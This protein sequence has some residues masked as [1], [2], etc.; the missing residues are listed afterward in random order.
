[1]SLKATKD[2]YNK[3]KAIYKEIDDKYYDLQSGELDETEFQLNQLLNRLRDLKKYLKYIEVSDL[4]GN[5][6][7]K[8]IDAVKHNLETI[9]EAAY[10]WERF[11]LGAKY[12]I[13]LRDPIRIEYIPNLKLGSYEMR[14]WGGNEREVAK[15]FIAAITH[16]DN[17]KEFERSIRRMAL[18]TMSQKEFDKIF[19]VI[20]HKMISV[21]KRKVSEMKVPTLKEYS[22]NEDFFNPFDED[23]LKEKKPQHISDK[24][25]PFLLRK[26][27]FNLARVEFSKR[28]GGEYTVLAKTQFAR[29]EIVEICPVVI[30]GEEA[31]TIDRLKD[32]IFEIDRDKNEWALVLGYGSLYRHSDKANLDYAYN[33]LTKQMYFITNKTVKHGEEL[34]INYGQDYWMERMT[35]N[36]MTDVE[37]TD[38]NQGMPIISGK[39]V[40]KPKVKPVTKDLEESEVQPNASD[41]KNTENIRQ[42]SS[43]NN[44]ANPVI[45]GVAII[46]SGQS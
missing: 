44:P 2:N 3:A 38:Q 14:I 26:E 16:P 4:E 32:I 15:R 33:R 21:P 27:T 41:I 31:K 17:I 13:D 45:S 6:E 29:G 25:G 10:Y 8:T 42:I 11:F 34:S 43:P 9:T 1:M 24:S 46:G 5:Y 20:K 18:G 23:D 7:Q 37:R 19:N 40:T 12:A 35:F 36:K 28:P 39:V 22:L 30:L